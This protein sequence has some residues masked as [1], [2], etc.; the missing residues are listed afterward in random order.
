[1]ALRISLAADN[2]QLFK[3]TAVPRGHNARRMYKKTADLQE[4]KFLR[5]F[6]LKNV[7][8]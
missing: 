5:L 4:T 1:M 2:Y 6:D 7:H 3:E 8:Y